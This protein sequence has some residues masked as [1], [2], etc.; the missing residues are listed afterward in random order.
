M[1]ELSADELRGAAFAANLRRAFGTPAKGDLP[2]RF[3][4]LLDRLGEI[5]SPPEPAAP[6]VPKRLGV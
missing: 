4:V 5:Q 2:Q 3:L 6:V 1:D